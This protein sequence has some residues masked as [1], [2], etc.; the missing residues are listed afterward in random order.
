MDRTYK[1][2]VRNACP[3]VTDENARNK[4]NGIIP[5]IVIQSG[6]LSPDERL[7]AG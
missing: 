6:Q 7:L 2:I 3:A 4:M 5:D 1:G